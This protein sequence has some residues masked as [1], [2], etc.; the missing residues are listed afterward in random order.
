MQKLT[1]IT[2]TIGPTSQPK[3]VLKEMFAKGLN[4]CRLNFS[5]GDH[6]EHLG[7]IKTIRELSKELGHPIAIIADLQGPKN[8][9][10]DFKGTYGEDGKAN[11]T[12]LTVGQTFTFDS[13][14]E[15]GDNTRVNLP[16]ENVLKSLKVGDRILLNDGKMEMRVTSTAP[17]KVEAKLIHGTAIWDRRGFNLPDTEIDSSVLTAK[18]RAD[19]DFVLK[20]DPDFVAISFVQKPED[21]VETREF[22]KARTDKPVKI[23]VKLERPQAIER[24]EKIVDETDA[25]M[26]ARG[27][28]AIEAPFE[29]V[30]VWARKV[31]KLCR[32]QNKP[33]IMATQM[34]GT[35]Q[36]DQFPTRAEVSDVSNASYM[37]VDST[38]TSE[39]TAMGDHPALVVD[40]MARILRATDKD[41]IEKRDASR[42]VLASKENTWAESVAAVSVLNN[43]EAIVIFDKDGNCTRKIS[44]RRP[45]APIISVSDSEIVANQLCLSRGVTSIFD[46]SLYA[47][48]DEKAVLAAAGMAG[49]KAVII[50]DEGSFRM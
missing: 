30:P 27:D 33:F 32:N 34:L 19:L 24:I 41:V 15:P 48:K 45:N 17:G 50:V 2:S 37:K 8:R 44:A 9:I 10:G 26:F 42:F 7:K 18:D 22:I 25:L 46:A 47:S 29:M 40:T 21:V 49:A 5:H 13:S 14:K 38:M 31:L 23:I 28:L 35:M 20:H 6:E 3:E 4:V 43:A 39:E 11:K 16:D 1:K 36:T 12:I